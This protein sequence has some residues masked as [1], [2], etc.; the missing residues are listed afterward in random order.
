MYRLREMDV[1]DKVCE[2]VSMT[3][4]S[5][6]YPKDMVERCVRESEP[7][8]SKARRVRASTALALVL[9]VIGMALW[10]R[11]N[12]CQVWHKL[13]GKRSSLHPA[14]P[15]SA[16]SDSGLSGRRQALGSVCLQT[17]MQERCQVIAQ[18]AT[19]PS[20][21]FGRYRLMAIDGTVFNTPDT[22]ANAAAF[23]RSSNQYGPG[24]YPQVRCV[25]L[26]EC[27]SHG[28][29]GLEM[30]RYD[31]SEVHGAHHLLEQVGADMLVMVDAGITSGGLL[32][33]VREK[34]AHALGALEAGAWEHLDQQRRLCDGSVLAWVPPTG[35]GQTQYPLQRGMWVR[36]ISYRITDERLGEEGKVYRL[37]TTLLNPRVAPALELVALYHERWEVEL[38]IDEIKTHERMQRKVL[39]SKTPEGV[40]QELYGI[41]LA[42]YAVRALMA[43]A[44][45]E[46]NLDPD[47]LSFSE[48]LFHLTEMI[49]LALTLEPEEATEPLL[50]RLQHKMARIV[51]PPRRLRINRREVKQV[52]NKYKPKK[53]TVPPPEPFEPD[54]Q[55]LD[56]VRMLDPLALQ[57]SE[58]VL[59]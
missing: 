49:D 24:A 19:M 36:L 47:R 1:D 9:F 27:G 5:K 46:G 17:L 53:R 10:S 23:G 28:V 2:Q 14:E 13:V 45:T 50:K 59:K 40:Y 43:Q 57:R 33:H 29:V 58:G 48:G 16:M 4:L 20:A 31:V 12:Q 37:V 39:R 52:Y 34:H 21:F 26:A 8:S 38:V 35:K 42:H 25:L 54:D 11:L 15:E 30:G 51:L 44:A 22:P 41:F 6:V 56:F 7:W 32:E 3:M 18:P 55:F